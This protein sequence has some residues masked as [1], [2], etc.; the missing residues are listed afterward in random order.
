VAFQLEAAQVAIFAA[1][2]HTG[3]NAA[4]LFVLLCCVVLEQDALIQAIM[5]KL[6]PHMQAQYHISADG[7]SVALAIST[8][9]V[10]GS[11]VAAPLL[12]RGCLLP[13]ARRL[14][15]R[16]SGGGSGRGSKG[17][18]AANE[19]ALLPSTQPQSE[20]AAPSARASAAAPAA[21]AS[22]P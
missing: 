21:A 9:F 2:D 11:L 15:A 3:A 4:L 14:R 1:F 7:V 10:L 20:E 18:A 19:E 5:D 17:A 13:A 12:E 6:P 22:D 16:L 8:F